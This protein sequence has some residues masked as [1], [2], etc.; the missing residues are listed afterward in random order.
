MIGRIQVFDREYP[1]LAP[2]ITGLA[3]WF[4]DEREESQLRTI[5]E[6]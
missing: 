3:K 2:I 4:S 6:L 5:N 1:L